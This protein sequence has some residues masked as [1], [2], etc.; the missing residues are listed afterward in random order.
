MTHLFLLHLIIT[1]SWV[2]HMGHASVQNI[3][4]GFAIGYALL[5]AYSLLAKN[6]YHIRL[7][8]CIMLFFYFH[9]EL[10]TSSVKVLWDII[11]PGHQNTPGF[12]AMPLEAKTPLEIFFTANMI[13]LTPGTLSIAL[14][15]DYKTLFIHAMFIEDK[16]ATLASLKSFET[17]ILK[18]FR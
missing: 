2:I 8:Q 14:S 4:I 12:L 1:V 10:I 11:T 16:E 17:T 9:Y 6:R 7:L 13:S 18:A 5:T 3:L 15:E